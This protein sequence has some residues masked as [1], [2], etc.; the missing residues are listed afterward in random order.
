MVALIRR[1]AGP[2]EPE[3]SHQTDLVF[4]RSNTVTKIVTNKNTSQMG[5]STNF[6]IYNILAFFSILFAEMGC[7][8]RRKGTFCCKA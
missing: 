5:Y 3:Y 8:F 2:A 6:Q 7:I 1:T 4:Y